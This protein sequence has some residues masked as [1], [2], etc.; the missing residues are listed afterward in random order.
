M[1]GVSKEAIGYVYFV[2][3][4]YRLCLLFEKNFLFSGLQFEIILK[5]Q[6]ALCLSQETED[7]DLV[8]EQ[9]S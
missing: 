9:H 5:C 3:G 2:K 7:G 8:V 6:L 1:F 4:G